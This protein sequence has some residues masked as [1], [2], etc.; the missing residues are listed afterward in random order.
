[1]EEE[2]GRVESL[3]ENLRI[4]A[5]V[6]VFWL[7]SGGLPTYEIIINGADP[8]KEHVEAVETCLEGQDWWDE[9]QKIRGNRGISATEDLSE[10]ASIF[11]TGT[12]PN[13]S[14]QEGPRV[15][16]AER[17]LGLRKLL[18]KSKRKLTMS[19]MSRL[20]VSL[21]M[22]A[23][24]LPPSVIQQH[25]SQGSASENSGSDDDGESDSDDDSEG[26][27]PDSVASEADMDDFTSESDSSTR[28]PLHR[29]RSHGDT[30]RGPPPSK[31]STGEREIVVP[32][33]IIRR[34]WLNQ[35]SSTDPATPVSSA[36]DLPFTLPQNPAK[37]AQST[38]NFAE[39]LKANSRSDT[40]VNSM[41]SQPSSKAESSSTLPA[42]LKMPSD[43]TGSKSPSTKEP[44]KDL[45]NT[46]SPK[47]PTSGLSRHASL[48]KF[49]SNPVPITRVATED[50]PGPSIMFANAPSPPARRGR[51]PSAYQ[52]SSSSDHIY[53]APEDDF[54]STPGPYSTG[55]TYSTQG[56]PLSFNDL[57]CRAQH[58]ILNELIRQQSADTA[59]LFTTLPSPVEGTSKSEEDCKRYLTDLEIL[60]KDCPPALMVHSNSMTVTMSL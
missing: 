38:L 33:P 54:H 6:L 56:L 5:E 41:A 14:F 57:P 4:E 29:R 7:A 35:P 55:S 3:L 28:R 42:F 44:S 2:T 15:E 24:S 9:I 20:G 19:G 40:A 13:A 10:I 37:A 1:V 18:R 34:T 11:R 53:E 8:G 12:W 48:P 46:E 60:C 59:V 49:S 31:K 51:I 58:L 22:R 36:Q 43:G 52:P 26:S 27:W 23:Q 30:M 21:G 17:F 39:S 16:R 50:G 25:A 47:R 45:L 32:K